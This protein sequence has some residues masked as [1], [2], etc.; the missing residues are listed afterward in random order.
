MCSVQ[1]WNT[2][3]SKTSTLAAI[4]AHKM[5]HLYFSTAHTWSMYSVS[6]A[7]DGTPLQGTPA[8]YS[9]LASIALTHHWTVSSKRELAPKPFFSILWITL[10]ANIQNLAAVLTSIGLKLACTLFSNNS[11]PCNHHTVYLLCTVDTNA[12]SKQSSL[13]P[14]TSYWCCHTENV[15]NASHIQF[16][17]YQTDCNMSPNYNQ[18]QRT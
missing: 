17:S 2:F 6:V 4:L 14:A 15:W 5:L 7:V 12:T 8:V 13:T 9:C 3:A 16:L 1:M 18:N 11:A 10:Y